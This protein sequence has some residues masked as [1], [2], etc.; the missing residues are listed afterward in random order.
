MRTLPLGPGA[1]AVSAVGYG[2]MH[3]SIDGRPSQAESIRAIHASLD[4]GVTLIDTANVYC[5]SD[6]DLGHNER[7]IARA[8]GDWRGPRSSVLVAT[9][10]G[11]TRPGGGW[12]RDG[13]PASLKRAC[14]QSLKALAVERI[15]LYQLHAPDPAVPLEE[16]IGAL[17]DLQREGKL[18]RIGLSNVSVDQITRA[19]RVAPITT[20]QNRLNPWFREALTTGVVAHCGAQGIGFLAYSP[21]G[22]GRLTRK[23]PDHPAARAVATRRGISPHQAVIAW[24]LAQGPTVIA[25]PSSRKVEHAIDGAGAGSLVLPPEDLQELSSAEWSKA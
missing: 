17:G 20:V 1:P 18:E 4:A 12:E 24:V 8:L 10:G 5:L 15:A 6:D 16:S 25:I 23:I 3:L 2:G 7:L 13:R 21:T 9:K 14:E 19:A 22:G 11:L